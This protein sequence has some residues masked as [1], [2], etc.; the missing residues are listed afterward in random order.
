MQWVLL[1]RMRRILMLGTLVPVLIAGPA[2]LW[3]LQGG[4]EKSALTMRMVDIHV[5]AA[6]ILHWSLVLTLANLG[7]QTH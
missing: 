7:V 4:D 1:R 6:I 2:R 5:S 3:P